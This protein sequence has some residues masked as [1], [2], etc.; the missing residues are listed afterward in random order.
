MNTFL[1]ELATRL[2][3]RWLTALVA[4]GLLWVA[5]LVSATRLGQ[6]APFELDRL[7]DW[8]DWLTRQPALHTPAVVILLAVTAV[9]TAGAVGLLAGAL[10]GLAERCWALPGAL[11]PAAWLLT[12]R[13][14]RW[15]WATRRLREAVLHAVELDAQ[16]TDTGRAD[17]LALRR[18]R[19]RVRLGPARPVR[20]T[21]IGDRYA[22]TAERVQRING[23]D[24]LALAWP[25]LWTVLPDSLRTEIAAAR[26]GTSDAARLFGWGTLYLA[27]SAWRWPAALLG[28]AIFAVATVR[29]RSTSENLSALIETAVDLHSADLSERL[30]LPST[31][32]P[33][34]AG[35]AITDR[36]RGTSGRDNEDAN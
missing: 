21:R 13:R 8:L 24:D 23:L 5:V 10:G 36:L 27:I 29:A 15:D 31:P 28:A 22:R 7:S 3:D 11:P 26:G 20:P 30:G 18:Q 12:A 25:R 16:G 9:L 14:R 1:V 19:Q 32:S 4:P 2:M 33:V 6:D 34:A 35:R 17:A